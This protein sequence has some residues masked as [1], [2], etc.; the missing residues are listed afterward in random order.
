M[1]RKF[2]TIFLFVWQLF[3][4]FC[5]FFINVFCVFCF[6]AFCV[7]WTLDFEN[8]FSF[9]V[10][11]CVCAK[12]AE[13][14]KTKNKKFQNEKSFIISHFFAQNINCS[15]AENWKNSQNHKFHA[16]NAQK[17]IIFERGELKYRVS[18][19]GKNVPGPEFHSAFNSEIPRFWNPILRLATPKY[20]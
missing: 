15:D 3:R 18:E 14:S 4:V 12:S 17:P 16:K 7:F 5:C 1:R 20:C 2:K 10:C 8:C 13:N 9:C 6:L 11:V 19:R